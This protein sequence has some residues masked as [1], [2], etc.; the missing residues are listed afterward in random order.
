V[1]LKIVNE[2]RFFL[3]GTM[4]HILSVMWERPLPRERLESQQLDQTLGG[5]QEK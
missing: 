5:M 1:V 2:E 3:C 4:E